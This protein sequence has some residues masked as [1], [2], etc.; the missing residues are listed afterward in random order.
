MSEKL[1]YD[2]VIGLEI[3]AELNTKTKIF[4][5]CKNDP[6]AAANEN[7]CPVCLGFPGALPSVSRAS[8]EKTI[9]AGLAFDCTINDYCMFERKNY[10]YPDL[11]KAYQLSQLQ[12]P[13][14]L[15]G[16]VDLKSGKRIQL[17]RIHLE[18]DAGKLQH[19][20]VNAE[21]HVDLNRGGCAL[22][23]MVTEADLNS[24]A[25]AVEFL[26]EVRSRLV[27]SDV[28]YCK[29]EEG[30]MRCD[31]NIS[32][33]PRGQKKLGNRAELK[34]INSFR[35]VGRAIEYEIKR[36]SALLND[37]KTV[38]VETRKWNDARCASSSMRSKER[39][40]DYRYFPD[41]DQ[42]GIRIEK[43]EVDALRKVLP[44]L[45]HGYRAEFVEKLGLPAYDADVLTREKGVTEFFVES[46]KLFDFPKKLSNWTM[47]HVLARA[48]N[49]E[50][51]IAPQQ[52]VDLMKLVDD[53]KVTMQNALVVLDEIWGKTDANVVKVAEKLNVM[54]GVS[55]A[56][57]EKVI[58]D[59]IAANPAAVADYP[60]NPEKVMNFF[61]GQTMKATRGAADSVV[62][63][64][65]LASS[66]PK[67]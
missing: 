66:L 1:R 26:E 42:Y 62:V 58:N 39:D 9:T 64:K 67:K 16:H 37:G 49:W 21:T 57:L 47:T 32:L 12:K 25:E 29:M 41:P 61:M 33:K 19:D 14:C 45:A 54:G 35:S 15:G 53:K 55:T 60:A 6:M 63:R 59:L 20:E 52:L 65:I 51:L 36:Q 23:E 13:I 2:V 18:E 40:V 46:L 34:N 8:I 50:I 5:P 4:C 44:R 31:V 56:E 28:A 43:K 11:P 10:F 24:A 3:H 38:P 22:I 30:G 7:V 17:N 27:F 48:K